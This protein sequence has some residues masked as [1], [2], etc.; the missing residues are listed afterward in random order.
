MASVAGTD[1][2]GAGVGNG[3]GCDDEDEAHVGKIGGR[4]EQQR[5]VGETS[6]KN[7]ARFE[8]LFNHAPAEKK[9][10]S[11]Q[12]KTG[13]KADQRV[14]G[15]VHPGQEEHAPAEKNS[16]A[17]RGDTACL[18]PEKRKE[19]PESEGGHQHD[20]QQHGQPAHTENAH[21]DCG[22]DKPGHRALDIHFM[23]HTHLSAPFPGSP[24]TA[25]TC[26][27]VFP[28]RRLRWA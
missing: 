20:K 17:A 22:H 24:A 12:N 7:A 8:G 6:H 5:N 23:I 11:R 16:T 18:P 27:C 25:S 9:T 14:L 21:D 2:V 13:A 15:S 19:F 4:Q 1:E 28:K 26:S 3:H 10:D